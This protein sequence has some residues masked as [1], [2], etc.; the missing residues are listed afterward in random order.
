M[1]SLHAKT[2]AGEKRDL[3][4]YALKIFI[5]LKK[6]RTEQAEDLIQLD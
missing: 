6:H 3:A 4:K 2:S 5:E 1:R